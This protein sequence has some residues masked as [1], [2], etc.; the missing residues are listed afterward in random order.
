MIVKIIRFIIIALVSSTALSCSVKSPQ[1]NIDSSVEAKIVDIRITETDGKTIVEVEGEKPLIYTTFRLSEPD[2]LIVDMA[3]VSLAQFTD[4]IKIEQG[5][6]KAVR[7]AVG[8]ATNVSRLEF[9]LSGLVETEVKT[10]NGNLV[11]EATQLKKGF[12]FFENENTETNQTKTTL[13]TEEADPLINS[14]ITESTSQATIPSTLP[15]VEQKALVLEENP[16]Q[17]NFAPKPKKTDLPQKSITLDKAVSPATAKEDLPSA[18]VVKDIYFD[19][20]GEIQLVIIS[21]GELSPRIFRVD[22]KRLVVDLPDVTTTMKQYRVNVD[23]PQIKRVRIGQHPEKIRLVLDLLAPIEVS[24][25]EQKQNEFRITFKNESGQN[26]DLS[27]KK[28]TENGPPEQ[29]LLKEDTTKILKPVVAQPIPQKMEQP[30]KSDLKN[31]EEDLDLLNR[32]PA[33][34]KNQVETLLKEG[35]IVKEKT[36]TPRIPIK[37]APRSVSSNVKAAPPKRDPFPPQQP[38]YKGKRLSLD[39]QDADIKNIIRLIAD[40]SKLNFVMGDDVK[41]KIT[42]KLLNVPWDQALQTILSMNRLGQIREGNI[43]RI[44]T[45]SN[46]ASQREEEAQVREKKVRVEDLTSH[47]IHVNYSKAIDLRKLLLKMLSPRGDIMVDQRV[48]TLI[49]KD[50]Q[51]KILAITKLV[52]ILDTKTPQVLIEARIVQVQ[53]S[54]EKSLGIKW[55]ADFSA[56][57]GGNLIGI[58]NASSTSPFN[59]PVPDFAVNLPAAPNFGGI[60][61]SFGRLTQNAFNLDLRLSAGQTQGLTRIVSTPKISVL[62]NQEARIEQGESFPL[63]T[64]SQ[65]GTQTNF[66]DANLVLQVTPHIS[67]D[68]GIMM[69][70]IIKKNAVGETRPGASG[71]SIIKK[72][73]ATNVLVMNGDTVVIGGIYETTKTN[74]T[75]GIPYLMNVPYLGSLFK[76][77]TKREN[78]S[79]LLVFIT[80]TILE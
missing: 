56:S 59:A 79:E 25:W 26:T 39:F 61:F 76:T 35:P 8:D 60:G 22:K 58:G 47:V 30:T 34:T 55:G 15:L 20:S 71:P 41:G 32:P 66:F 14:N 33:L 5:P 65:Q 11:V 13:Q 23:H 45:L 43:I 2:R 24:S 63:D 80:P 67:A 51:E 21:D 31:H 19:Q 29:T 78:T 7:P 73:A 17:E 57:T 27:N 64:T 74:S 40:V 16:I 46:L 38:K 12:I 72:E 42:L 77:T 4:E 10:I 18:K 75:S 1:M 69:E 49:V 48:N 44:A 37:R 68:G 36:T 53:P 3:S 54:F 70:I 50:V 6:I 28:Q 9:A 62:D 52:K